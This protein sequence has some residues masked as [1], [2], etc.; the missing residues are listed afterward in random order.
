M[1]KNYNQICL[2]IE[3][4]MSCVTALCMCPK[5]GDMDVSTVG[6]GLRSKTPNVAQM[7]YIA[8]I[9]ELHISG[10]SSFKQ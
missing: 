5:A 2:N 6:R 9:Y 1:G 3:F 10:E 7:Y 8:L 4:L